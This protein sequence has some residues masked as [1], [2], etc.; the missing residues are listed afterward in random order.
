[1]KFS[2]PLARSAS[3]F[4]AKNN[5][6]GEYRVLAIVTTLELDPKSQDYK[7]RFVE[8][9]SKAAEDYL[10]DSDEATAFVLINR[11]KDWHLLR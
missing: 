11:P 6:E 1:M 10:A 2:H 9:L 7:K 8:R 5:D 4:T 3:V